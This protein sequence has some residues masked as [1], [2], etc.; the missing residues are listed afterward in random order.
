MTGTPAA[1]IAHYE[2]VLEAVPHHAFDLR[3]L[4]VD[5]DAQRLHIVDGQRVAQCRDL[6]ALAK[7]AQDATSAR[8]AVRA[9]LPALGELGL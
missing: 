7:H 6:A 8:D 3:K 1:V 5:G 9:A 2:D 4:D